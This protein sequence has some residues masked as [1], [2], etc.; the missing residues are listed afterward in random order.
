[1]SLHYVTF[2]MVPWHFLWLRNKHGPFVDAVGKTM[3]AN[4]M[5]ASF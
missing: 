1:L 5:F 2:V 4:T 3:E